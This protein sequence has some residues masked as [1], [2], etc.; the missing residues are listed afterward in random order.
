MKNIF[1]LTILSVLTLAIP[2]NSQTYFQKIAGD[3][4]G[5]LEYLDY[6]EDK[7]VKLKTYLTVTPAND[8]NSA[9]FIT[10]YDDFGRI[11]KEMETVRIDAMG[12][13][14]ISGNF[15]Y[16]IGSIA[17]GKIVLLSSGQDGDKVEP[18]RETITFDETSL[19]FLKE[20]RTPWQFRNQTVLKRTNENVLAKRIL[21]A[22]QMKED[23]DVLKKTLTT[24]HPG[25][26]R[27]QTPESL[28]K[29]LGAFESKLVN[30]FPEG[31]FFLLVSQFAN[32]IYCGHTFA[33]P[34]N[35]DGILRERLFNGKTYLP[36]YFRIIDGKFIVTENASSN[37]L[38]KGSEI[39]KI[40]GIT[41]KAII[42]KL[43]TVTKSDGR[44]T[45]A[46]R[47]Q[48]IELPRS[49]AERYALFDWYF[50]LFFPLKGETYTIEAVDFQS[51]KPVKFQ[52]SAMMKTERTAEMAKRYGASP[53][54]DDGWKFEIKE[55]STAYLKI[56]NS[57]TWRLKTIKFKE[58][59]ANAFSEMRTKNIKN[60]IVD[61]RGNGGGDMTIGYELAKY[62]ANKELP[63]Y[64]ASRRLIRTV[65]AQPDLV[66]NLQTYN[67]GLK[68]ALQNG[69]QKE[70]YKTAESNFFEI[71]PSANTENFPQVTP[72]DNSFRG[73]AFVISDAS[74]ASAT[75]QF[76]NYVKEN[77]L[78]KIVG[79]TSG[80]NKQGIN[81][82]S[83][84]FL[85]LPN[86]KVEI[87]VPVYFQA[88]LAAQKDEGVMPDVFVNRK[89]PDIGLGI[90][91]EVTKVKNLIEK[92]KF[93]F[94]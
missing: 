61:L 82:G 47:V 29:I 66:K 15:E 36:F 19:T 26:Y 60:L 13:K 32:Q 43:L 2:A 63:V 58:F 6:K 52:T 9:E 3:W 75:F 34:Y 53:T 51:K 64:A 73:N 17:D 81:G 91:A 78:A 56:D 38:S 80:G 1:V 8:G 20:T 83:Y 77:K 85:S 18:I 41:G 44:N 70:I 28:K 71:L 39:T 14:Y 7:R 24:L 59:L 94:L 69:V 45:V 31:E 55:D 35:Q 16:A 12:K 92:I 42:E 33:N 5:T 40:N 11:I 54:Y 74:N 21:T 48:S 87:D 84:F 89:A 65:T 86:S 88:P 50:P 46:H 49:E 90:D 62:L 57:I 37:N 25:I 67:D 30:S 76:L 22:V 23:F 4:E 79:Q 27:Y 93:S 72:Y 10:I 68:Y